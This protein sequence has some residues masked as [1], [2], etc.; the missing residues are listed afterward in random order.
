MNSRDF[1]VIVYLNYVIAKKGFLWLE[2]NPVCVIHVG[3]GIKGLQDT[4][5]T[6]I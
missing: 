2:M 4:G 5:N 3:P 1:R 6:S